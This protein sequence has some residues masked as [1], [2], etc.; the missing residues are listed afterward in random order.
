MKRHKQPSLKQMV[1]VE[2]MKMDAFE[3]EWHTLKWAKVQRSM[4]RL[5]RYVPDLTGEL[6]D[7]RSTPADH[8]MVREE[9]S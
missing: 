8:G 4:K 7:Y 6:K 5:P 3:Q 2:R 1:E 9:E